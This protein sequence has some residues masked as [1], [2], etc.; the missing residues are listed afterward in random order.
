MLRTAVVGAT[1]V[2][3]VLVFV[4][5]GFFP[6]WVTGS[7]AT[8]YYYPQAQKVI[9]GSLPY[10]DFATSYSPLFHALLL[11]LLLVWR[12]VGSIVLTMLAVETIMLIVYLR[13]FGRERPLQSW[14]IAFVYCTSPISVYWV[15]LTGYNGIVVAISVLAGLVL[16]HK[17][18]S[19]LSSVCLVLGLLFS[20]LLAV[21]GW[22]AVLFWDTRSLKKRMAVVLAGTAVCYLV[23]LFFGFDTLMPIHREFG[24]G[25]SGNIW[26]LLNQVAGADLASNRIWMT[27]PV[28]CYAPLAALFV[29]RYF[30]RRA[31]SESGDPD[32]A[33]ALVAIL[34]LSFMALSRKSY[35]FYFPMFF[36]FLVHSVFSYGGGMPRTSRMLPMLF[37][38]AVTT[39]EPDLN[40]L[41]REGNQSPELK[42]ALMTLDAALLGCY[43]YYVYYLVATGLGRSNRG[44]G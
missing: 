8:L 43:A 18:R 31:R 25:T 16:A 4:I 36:I 44:E 5:Y 22:P 26:F 39:L 28:L 6:Q 42:L 15:G 7:D 12:S 11:P 34:F 41:M 2:K 30:R 37:L 1:L 19:A 24:R 3:I 14:R 10:R 29:V 35:L 13:A 17:G 32:S 9:S 33:M 23:P 38:G 40:R 21:I 20:K 27:L